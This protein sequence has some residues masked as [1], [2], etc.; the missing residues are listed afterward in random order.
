MRGTVGNDLLSHAVTHILP[1]ALAGL[2][3][4]FEMEPGVPPPLLS[5]TN[6]LTFSHKSVVYSLFHASRTGNDSTSRF[7]Y[8]P[9]TQGYALSALA[10]LS[11]SATNLVLRHEL[12]R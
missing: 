1:S 3:S 7:P 12:V 8:I 11:M 10:S 2:T 6:L 5:P 9:A 4:G